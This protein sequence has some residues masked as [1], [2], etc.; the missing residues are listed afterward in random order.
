MSWNTLIKESQW[1]LQ[2]WHIKHIKHHGINC[3]DKIKLNH[4]AWSELCITKPPTYKTSRHSQISPRNLVHLTG[5]NMKRPVTI[6]NRTV[7]AVRLEFNHTASILTDR[8][9][10]ERRIL[11]SLAST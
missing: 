11:L 6:I 10:N 5:G 4:R 1:L 9:T 3:V 7:V 8:D 2:S